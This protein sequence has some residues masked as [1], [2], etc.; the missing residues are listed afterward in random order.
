MTNRSADR[1]AGI[2]AIAAGLCW[3]TWAITNAATRRGLET[4]AP[5]SGLM[6]F[7]II[8]TVAWNLLL[9]PTALRL[10]RAAPSD[11]R[12]LALTFTSAG[13]LSVCLW[14]T[15]AIAGIT[16]E[17]EFAYLSLASIWL[18]GGLARG[19]CGYI[20]VFWGVRLALQWIFDVKEHLSA[21]W[22]RLGYYVLT[23]LFASFTLLYGFAALQP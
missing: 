2:S 7:G 20:A 10:Y 17:L 5:G 13:I 1:I 22:L 18:L 9:I 19:V 21:W 11:H 14:A 6:R 15:G 12:R 23:I 3:F 4:S 16:S 8:L